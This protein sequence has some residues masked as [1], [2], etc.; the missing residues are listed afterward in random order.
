RN[1]D[2]ALPEPGPNQ[3][4]VKLHP[5]DHSHTNVFEANDARW[6]I[7]EWDPNNPMSPRDWDMGHISGHEYWRLRAEYLGEHKDLEYFLKDYLNPENYEVSD[8]LR[9]RS[10]EDE[11][12]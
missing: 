2:L 11:L 7:V 3:M 6:R 8:P 10:H 12:A 5:H 9:N 4:Y 1:G